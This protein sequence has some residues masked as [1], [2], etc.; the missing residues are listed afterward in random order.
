MTTS[1]A[2]RTGHLT[3]DEYYEYDPDARSSRGSP[4][5]GPVKP[6]LGQEPNTEFATPRNVCRWGPRTVR[7][8][9]TLD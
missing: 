7:L 8:L 1:A 5:M 2:R 9:T 6:V 3:A 4:Q